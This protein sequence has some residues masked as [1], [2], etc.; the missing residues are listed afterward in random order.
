[1]LPLLSIPPWALGIAVAIAIATSEDGTCPPKDAK[2]DVG[3]DPLLTPEATFSIPQGGI[4]SKG[5]KK[6]S[7]A[8]AT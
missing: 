3:M 5:P 4:N 6:R 8:R 7:T 1:M 2:V